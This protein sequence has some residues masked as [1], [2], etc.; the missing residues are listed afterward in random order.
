MNADDG[1]SAPELRQRLFEALHS[2]GIA[3][4]IKANIR[5][6]LIEQLRQRS[7]LPPQHDK[8]DNES[9]GS[10]SLLL[11][12]A[13]S[14]VLEY[15]N[16]RGFDF[17]MSV[18]IPEC[19]LA[20]ST[21][22]L[23]EREI[24]KLLHL[25]RPV[26]TMAE[27][28]RTIADDNDATPLLVRILDGM[29]HLGDLLISNR[30]VQTD[31]S[32]VEFF[33]LTARNADREYAKRINATHPHALVLEERM[34]RY[35]QEVDV[36]MKGELD[37][38]LRRFKETEIVH[39]R[40]EER[41]R[42][43]EDL[44][45]HRSEFE[46]I[47]MERRAKTLEWEQQER[48][49][50]EEREKEFERQ[51]MDLRQRL[52]AESNRVVLAEAAH[53]NE[54]QL[55]AR[56]LQT[57]KDALQRRHEEALTQIVELQKFK[58]R[59]AEKMQDAIA[60]HKIDLNREHATILSNVEV[61]KTKLEA[62][63]ALLS[64]RARQV[65]QAAQQV[66]NV[67]SEVEELQASL[68]AARTRLAEERKERENAGVLLRELQMQVQ[69]QKSSTALEYEIQS[70][71]RQLLESEKTAEKRQEEYQSLLKSLMAPK[72]EL[73]TELAR[74]RKAEG[75]WQRECQQLVG[76]L[77]LELTRNEEIHRKYEDEVLRVKELQREVADLR[78]LLHQAQSA[79]TNEVG[80]RG[81]G[82]QDLLMGA[83]E[84]HI[85]IPRQDTTR[86]QSRNFRLPDPLRYLYSPSPK[87]NT[88]TNSPQLY[89]PLTLPEMGRN[90]DFQDLLFKP[91]PQVYENTAVE[92]SRPSS[93]IPFQDVID[94]PMI[95]AVVRAS[96]HQASSVVKSES[97][98]SYVQVQNV[99][100]DVG[101]R[102]VKE[103]E[104]PKKHDN[105]DEV[106]DPLMRKYIAIVKER[107]ER[108]R[109]EGSEGKK[110]VPPSQLQQPLVA[111]MKPSSIGIPRV[112]SY[113]SEN[114]SSMTS[115]SEEESAGGGVAFAAGAT[116]DSEISGPSYD[117]TESRDNAW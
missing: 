44:N 4:K 74:A 50:L 77:D 68:R 8:K 76:K 38:Q 87:P 31:P 15:L 53:R 30:E 88:S 45:Q 103:T 66:S 9:G 117:S 39:V 113:R 104:M 59:Y 14:I 82:D 96:L 2:T 17:T 32:P 101:E 29:A 60:Q 43:Q 115:D 36:R 70:L 54:A 28:K 78:L 67:Q 41:R 100:D 49:R 21:Q 56:E 12:A 63:R 81:R 25:E 114:P 40:V 111:S 61:E 48:A 85:D 7:Q 94:K 106:S 42:Y 90:L 86:P 95:A 79:L 72:H 10:G 84:Y 108:E 37:E 11:R 16:S 92:A 34:L 80:L 93:T 13:D 22:V 116:N 6:N 19:G 112:N 83:E 73:E 51:N 57:E 69:N 64:E 55:L 91:T 105:T 20:V 62:E 24:W 75:R 89:Q 52:L 33:D 65:E 23:T 99:V 5:S 35:Q 47:D 26:G 3:D 102:V 18:F 97:A 46:K 27:L 1:S 107:R 109:V 110:D 58:D 71:K 98:E